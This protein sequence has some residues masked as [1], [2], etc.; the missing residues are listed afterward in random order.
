MTAAM[1]GQNKRNPISNSSQHA[2]RRHECVIALKM[3]DVAFGLRDFPI[4]TWGEIVIPVLRPRFD[5]FD[6][7]AAINL[8][9]RQNA[10][11]IGR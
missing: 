8:T 4:E 11:R 7:D 3:Y 1:K 2:D 6:V 10:G 5:P 9:F